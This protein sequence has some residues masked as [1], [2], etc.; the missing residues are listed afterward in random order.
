MYLP[1]CCRVVAHSKFTSLGQGS[2]P[3]NMTERKTFDYQIDYRE[4][5]FPPTLYI[6]LS[7]I[8]SHFPP[9][10]GSFGDVNAK[11]TL[12]WSCVHQRQGENYFTDIHHL[13]WGCH[14][15]EAVHNAI[16]YFFLQSVISPCRMRKLVRWERQF[17]HI[18]S[19]TVSIN[20]P[21]IHTIIEI[22]LK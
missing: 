2:Q 6:S 20:P 12:K 17:R 7:C 5:I 8:L 16:N 10:K 22:I 19:Y 21:N 4:V 13:F 11:N 14:A 3:H 15:I 9:R 1:L 18:L